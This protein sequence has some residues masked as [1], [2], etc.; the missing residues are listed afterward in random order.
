MARPF[1]IGM[2]YLS[3]IISIHLTPHIP[4]PPTKNSE[5]SSVSS[6]IKHLWG[7]QKPFSAAQA[8]S[9]MGPKLSTTRRRTSSCDCITSSLRIG[10]KIRGLF[11][12]IW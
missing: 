6:K 7:Y 4:I 5:K 10:A 11:G 12:D 9:R 1:P 8:S 2:I 3:D